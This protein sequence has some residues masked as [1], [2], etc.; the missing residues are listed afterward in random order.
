[1]LIGASPIV[2][3]MQVTKFPPNATY[4]KQMILHPRVVKTWAVLSARAL[5]LLKC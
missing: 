4:P 5:W 2:L 3:Q 1:M